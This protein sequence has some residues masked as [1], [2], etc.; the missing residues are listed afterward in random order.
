MRER[1][2]SVASSMCPSRGVGVGVLSGGGTWCR[3]QCANHW[4]HS[5]GL[6]DES[7]RVGTLSYSSPDIKHLASAH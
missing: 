5:P 2:Q 7:W 4:E 6:D 1:E 3:G